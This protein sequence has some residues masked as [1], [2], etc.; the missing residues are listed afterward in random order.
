M[1][2]L[3]AVPNVCKVRLIG[4]V[5][6]EPYV[7]IT[8]WRFVSGAALTNDNCAVIAAKF[9]NAWGDYIAGD[10]V[11]VQ[12]FLDS[13]EVT[14]LTTSTS[15]TGTA[16]SSHEGTFGAEA[17]SPAAC[18]LESKHVGRRY[19]GGHPRTYWPGVSA[20]NTE[21]SLGVTMTSAAYTAGAEAINGYY[22]AIPPAVTTDGDSGCSSWHEVCVHYVMGGVHLTDPLVDD[23]LSND[24]ENAIATQRRRLHRPGG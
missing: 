14:D 22:G 11:S 5:N 1:T 18:F 7:G 2:S 23:V 17:I 3:P 15:G 10:L 13:V 21:G 24:L 20:G 6:S 19:R 8:H 9:V 16:A 4:R 12:T